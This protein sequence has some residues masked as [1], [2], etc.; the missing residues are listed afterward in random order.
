MLLN[1]ITLALLSSVSTSTSAPSRNA[2]EVLWAEAV[3]AHRE[4]DPSAVEK[5]LW[6]WLSLE[7][8]MRAIPPPFGALSDKLIEKRQ[9]NGAFRI[10]ASRLPDRIRLALTDPA[11][12]LGRVQVFVKTPQ[13]WRLLSRLE[14]HAVNRFEFGDI[15]P[16]SSD[17]T[18]KI[19]AYMRWPHDDILIRTNYLYPEED[20]LQPRLSLSQ[21]DSTT[22]TCALVSDCPPADSKA[23]LWWT[24]AVGIFALGFAGGAVWQ[25]FDFSQK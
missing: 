3:T 10:Y 18:Y 17:A 22:T 11:E 23:T 16:L 6:Q 7:S 15:G 24:F 12:V 8:Q 20:Q 1:I 13:N 4:N 14:S 25:E 5:Y 9:A 2:S 19:E 21:T